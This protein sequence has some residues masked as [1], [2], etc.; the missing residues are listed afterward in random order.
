MTII[1][2]NCGDASGV[3]DVETQVAAGALWDVD[4]GT[5]SKASSYSSYIL[6]EC[7]NTR[8]LALIDA[9]PPDSKFEI[10]YSINEP[11]AFTEASVIEKAW[12]LR[13]RL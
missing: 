3:S 2:I 8:N 12:F 4:L 5:T 1:L 13:G 11:D 9:C 6:I 10:A 7:T